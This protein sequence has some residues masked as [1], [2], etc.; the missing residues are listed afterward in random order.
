MAGADAVFGYDERLG[1]R[2]C[3]GGGGDRKKVAQDGAIFATVGGDGVGVAG[4]GV[5]GG[6]T[7]AGTEKS[8]KRNKKQGE[9]T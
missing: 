2:G 6:K 7:R 8:D 3:G 9:K 4:K 5:G 1:G